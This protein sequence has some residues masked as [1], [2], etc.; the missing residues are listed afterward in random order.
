MSPVVAVYVNP[1]WILW[2][3]HHQWFLSTSTPGGNSGQ[4]ITSGFCLHQPLVDTPDNTSPVVS[5]YINPW[6][7]LRTTHHQWF[8]STST[9]GGHSGQHITSGFCL[10]QPLV[11]TP[12]NTS[13]VVSVYINLWWKLRTTHHQWF[14]STSTSGGH[15]GQHITS[16]F[17]LHQPLV[18]TPDNTSP[19]VSVYI[20]LWW[21]L[22]TTHHQWFLSTS[23]SGGHSGQHITSGFCLHQPLVDTPDNTSPVVSVYINLWWTLRTTHHQWFLSTSTPGGYSGQHIT[24]GFCLH[25]PLVETPDNTSP[26]VSVYIYLSAAMVFFKQVQL[27]MLLRTMQENLRFYQ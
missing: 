9:S 24:S 23:T 20:N 2:T 3:T 15:S 17:C 7:K 11:E 16:G 1:W 26:V 27:I 18:D 10:H 22:R 13:P 14:L 5:V 12:D 6:W 8:L 21:K 19:V 4:H 25:Q